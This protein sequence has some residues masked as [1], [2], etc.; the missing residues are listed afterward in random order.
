MDADT[1]RFA[2][3][4]T[5]SLTSAPG[6]QMWLVRPLLTLLAAGEPVT[7]GRLAAQAGRTEQQ[8]R[9]TLATMPDTEYDEEGR[10]TGFG[11][12]FNPTPHR[13]ETSG[14]TFYT[15]CALDTLGFPAV[16]GHTAQVTSPCRAT[17]EPVRLTVTPDGP[18]DVDPA[19]AVVSL[20]APDAPTSVRISFCDLVHFFSSADAAKDW[21]ADHPGAQ[22]LPVA[23]AFDV[24][25][26][27]VIE[28]ILAD[29]P[30]SGCC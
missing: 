6:L 30:P 2:A 18:A 15:W 21:L 25:G 7:V 24:V 4:L 28:Q 10:I 16:L 9:R 11:L 3:R 29:D 8:I 5:D 27:P 12:T 19:T 23:E 26:R 20:V 14:H 17:G 13:Y 1:Q 22:V